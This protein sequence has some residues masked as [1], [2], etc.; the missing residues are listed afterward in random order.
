MIPILTKALDPLP[1]AAA[2]IILNSL[3]LADEF[4]ACV[5]ASVH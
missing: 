2:T 4:P 3:E 5:R 1:T